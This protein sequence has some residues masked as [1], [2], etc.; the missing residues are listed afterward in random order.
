MY[1]HNYLSI[2]VALYLVMYVRIYPYRSTF[3]YTCIIYTFLLQ[4]QICINNYI[5]ISKHL[6]IL[7]HINPFS[8][9]HPPPT[10]YISKHMYI[11][12]IT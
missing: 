5:N 3:T 1:I 11:P 7:T 10:Y 8:R 12:H 4:T 2:Y 6:P 9:I